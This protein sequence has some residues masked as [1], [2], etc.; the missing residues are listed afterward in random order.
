[1]VRDLSDGRFCWSKTYL[2][3]PWNSAGSLVDLRDYPRLGKYLFNAE[4]TL[5]SRYVGRRQPELCR[6]RPIDR[7]C[8]RFQIGK[9]QLRLCR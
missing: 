6:Y 2:V 3:N 1:M 7:V 9:K 4:E 5:R 8:E